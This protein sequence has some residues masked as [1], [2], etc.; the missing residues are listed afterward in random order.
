MGLYVAFMLTK[1]FSEVAMWLAWPE[2]LQ[3]FTAQRWF[4]GE[5]ENVK[6]GLAKQVLYLEYI[7]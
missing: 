6:V 2:V 7:L 3:K 4:I 5:H 1:L